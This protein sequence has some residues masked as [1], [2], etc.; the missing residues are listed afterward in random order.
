MPVVKNSS[1][2]SVIKGS[3]DM[4]DGIATLKPVTS[5]GKTVAYYVTGKYNIITGYT[6]VIILGR[7]GAEIVAVL[8]PLGQ[9]SA[10]KLTAFIPKFGTQTLNI[11][12]ALTS[13]PANEQVSRI[14]TLTDTKT[15]Y[16]DFK[17]LFIGNI[18]SPASVKTFKWL[19]ECDTSA[20]D[21]GT[22]KEQ[23]KAGVGAVKQ[24]GK[25]NVQDVKKTVEAVK[26]SAKSTASDIK[27]QVQKTKESIEELKNMKNMFKRP[28]NNSGSQSSAE[29]PSDAVTS[30]P[31]AE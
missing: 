19:S 14:P 22:L 23:V 16:K 27:N 30:T 10:S 3:V 1:E 29:T 13:D 21:A 5:A 18:M 31:S 9:L 24:I 17:V 12:N 26:S 2:F 11:L 4:L 6:N 28:S 7:M 8:G 15:T 20:I 25:N